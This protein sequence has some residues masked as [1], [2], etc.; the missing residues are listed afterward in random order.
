MTG[1]PFFFL[2]WHFEYGEAAGVHG[3]PRGRIHRQDRS[4][5]SRWASDEV[6]S[7]AYGRPS[8][9]LIC[10]LHEVEFPVITAIF[11]SIRPGLAWWD[12]Y[13]GPSVD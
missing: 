3:E 6:C 4:V 8:L 11:G 13:F 12:R 1:H 7:T 2:L 5:A 10:R 9:W